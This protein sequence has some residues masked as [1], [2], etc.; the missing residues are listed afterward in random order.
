MKNLKFLGYKVTEMTFRV[1]PDAE[2]VRD[3]KINPKIRMDLKH[4]VKN[5]LLIVTVAIDK[6][7]DS[8]TPFELSFSMA[9]NFEITNQ[10]DIESLR[11]EASNFVFPYVRAS[12]AQF[13]TCANMPAYHLPEIDFSI[14][15]PGT[16]VY[17]GS[18]TPAPQNNA[19]NST[20]VIRP[21]DNLD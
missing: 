3:F 6:H 12:V 5:L 14:A 7:Q 20:I 13:T 4:N 16:A 10:T 18:P 17:G 2:G 1:N 8:I 9:S 15:K 19:T 21:L 11:I